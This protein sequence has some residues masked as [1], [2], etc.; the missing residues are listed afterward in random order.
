MHS[1]FSTGGVVFPTAREVRVLQVR[2]NFLNYTAANDFQNVMM[3]LKE[4]E[5]KKK[6]LVPQALDEVHISSARIATIWPRYVNAAIH[7]L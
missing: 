2:A 3:E 1:F 4:A 7:V 5:I 6:D